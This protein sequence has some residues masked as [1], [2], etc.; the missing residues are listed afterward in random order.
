[1]ACISMAFNDFDKLKSRMD[2]DER[3]MK[4]PA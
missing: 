4:D 1:M 2:M 3:R